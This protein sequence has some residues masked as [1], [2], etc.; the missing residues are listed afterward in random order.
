MQAPDQGAKGS[1]VDHGQE[2]CPDR[3]LDDM[4]GAFGMGA[5]GGGVWHF[6]KGVKNSPGNAR[7]RGGLEVT[8]R[9]KTCMSVAV[10]YSC[11]FIE[12]KKEQILPRLFIQ[13]PF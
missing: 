2:P 1:S 3:I 13:T 11:F 6:L 4:G 10:Y 9:Q 8:P 7:M 12:A 5:V